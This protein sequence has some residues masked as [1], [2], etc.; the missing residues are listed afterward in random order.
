M[1]RS[2]VVGSSGSALSLAAVERAATIARASGARL[3]IVRAAV[4][5]LPLFT[6]NEFRHPGRSHAGIETAIDSE[7]IDLENHANALRRQGIAVSTHL[8]LGPTCAALKTVAKTENADVIVVGDSGSTGRHAL[9][10]R[11]GRSLRLPT[12][13]VGPELRCAD[14]NH[15]A[16]R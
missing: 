16:A 10:K 1:Y 9:H 13:L 14:D 12:I 8:Q 6:I 3:H 15:A 11:L 4:V 5:P 2:I 7:S